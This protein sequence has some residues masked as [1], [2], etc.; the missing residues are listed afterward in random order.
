MVA[1]LLCFD[2]STPI[3]DQ[4]AQIDYWL[5]FLNSALPLS[6]IDSKYNTNSKWVVLPVGLKTDLPGATKSGLQ[7]SHLKI[8]INRFPHLPIF[9]QLFTVSAKENIGVGYL[10]QVLE[11]E[12]D[13]IFSRH[14]AMIPKSYRNIL[15]DFKALQAPTYQDVLYKKYS[16]GLTS[17]GFNIA[18]QY[19]H[20]IGRLAVLKTKLIFPDPMVASQIAAKFVSPEEVRKSLLTKGGVQILDK[21]QIENLLDIAGAGT[22]YVFVFCLLFDKFI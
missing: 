14:T 4:I 5:D 3:D 19:L 11:S 8:W 10:K 9:P 13:R 21:N 22:G 7:D 1:Y 15:M 17:E 20:A 18:I 6:Q 12:C 2:V 16:H